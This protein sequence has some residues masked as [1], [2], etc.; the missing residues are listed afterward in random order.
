M[1]NLG[2]QFKINQDDLKVNDKCI[3]I[4]PKYRIEVLTERLL[5]IE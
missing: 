2:P 4:G 3:F 5:R 1:Y